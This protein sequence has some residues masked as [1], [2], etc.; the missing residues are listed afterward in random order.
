MYLIYNKTMRQ[1]SIS[2]K[3]HLSRDIPRMLTHTHTHTHTDTCDTL[4]DTRFSKAI[5]SAGRHTLAVEEQNRD[6]DR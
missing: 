3:S 2:I 5:K 1:V 4:P 6:A